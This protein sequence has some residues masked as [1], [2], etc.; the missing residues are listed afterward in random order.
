[1]KSNRG[2]L[3]LTVA[4]TLVCDIWIWYFYFWLD[5]TRT[6]ECAITRHL[7]FQSTTLPRRLEPPSH[8]A[9]SWCSIHWARK[10]LPR[11]CLRSVGGSTSKPSKRPS[12]SR[13]IMW[14]VPS[15]RRVTTWSSAFPGALEVVYT[16]QWCVAV[17]LEIEWLCLSSIGLKSLLQIFTFRVRACPLVCVLN[18]C[19]LLELSY[20]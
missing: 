3:S 19:R 9:T 20:V 17:S 4:C 15:S 10:C 6:R 13:E 18:F 14:P 1:M 5:D 2:S 7:Y 11:P 8:I 16:F 12:R